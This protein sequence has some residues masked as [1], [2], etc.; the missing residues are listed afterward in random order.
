MK[1]GRELHTAEIAKQQ[2]SP[3]K[4]VC[5]KHV[6]PTSVGVFFKAMPH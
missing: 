4:S 3:Q 2:V 1:E 5:E 6:V